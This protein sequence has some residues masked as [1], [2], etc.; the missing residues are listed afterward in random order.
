M[1]AHEHYLQSKEALE[2]LEAT[3]I[4]TQSLGPATLQKWK[5]EEAEWKKDV[6]DLSKHKG[7]KNP[8]EPA[9]GKRRRSPMRCWFRAKVALGLTQTQALDELKTVPTLTS[10]DGDDLI[11]TIQRGIKLEDDKYVSKITWGINVDK[12]PGSV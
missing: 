6:K 10:V 7:L 12:H 1:D 3:V 11:G 5:E 8:Y 9:K 2:S 4:A